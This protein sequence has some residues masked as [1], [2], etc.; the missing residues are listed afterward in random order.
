M[1]GFDSYHNYYLT[2]DPGLHFRW[3][4]SQYKKSY[5]FD[6]KWILDHLSTNYERAARFSRGQIGRVKTCCRMML[7]DLGMEKSSFGYDKRISM[8][9]IV[10]QQLHF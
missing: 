7:D 3:H 9:E 4:H 2:E 8:E 6:S 1:S 10:E 5:A